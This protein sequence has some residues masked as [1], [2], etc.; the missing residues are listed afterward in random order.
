M[1]A[2]TSRSATNRVLVHGHRR[3]HSTYVCSPFS[4]FLIL[5]FFSFSHHTVPHK[6]S[7]PINFLLLVPFIQTNTPSMMSNTHFTHLIT[8]LSLYNNLSILTDPTRSRVLL[9]S[10]ELHPSNTRKSFTTHNPSF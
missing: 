8:H 4:S 3:N 7:T 2:L 9:N 6:A 5:L 1:V 10:H